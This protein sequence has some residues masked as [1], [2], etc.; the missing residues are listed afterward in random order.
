MGLTPAEEIHR[1]AERAGSLVLPNAPHRRDAPEAAFELALRSIQRAI[2]DIDRRRDDIDEDE[3]QYARIDLCLEAASMLFAAG[4]SPSEWRWWA[5][6]AA[7]T[8]LERGDMEAAATWAVVAH[9]QRIRARLPRPPDSLDRP[10]R[11]VWW[12]ASGP[13]VP[14]ADIAPPS[15]GND[16]TAEWTTL[17][18]SVPAADHEA[19]GKALRRITDFWLDED[20]DWDEFH[21]WSYPDFEPEVN[22]AAAL[23]R[24][25]GW[26]PTDWPDDAILFLEAGLAP[27]AP[28]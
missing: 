11:V 18:R 8:L 13:S 23:A 17:L 21:P 2:A 19:T 20:E 15:A 6:H 28:G 14:D 16:L 4:S 22:A 25:R 1:L 26:E 27:G 5:A 10:A 12:L 9:A 24:E 7:G 3:A